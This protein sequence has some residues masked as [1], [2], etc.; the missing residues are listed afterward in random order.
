M[1]INRIFALILAALMLASMAIACSKENT[2]DKHAE[3]NKEEQTPDVSATPE[4]TEPAYTDKPVETSDPNVPSDYFYANLEENVP[5]TCDLDFDGIDDTVILVAD[6]Q[7][8]GT[9]YSMQFTLGINPNNTIS[10]DFDMESYYCKAFITD[11]DRFDSRLDV[12][13]CFGY[14]SDD[15]TTCLYRV[16][17]TGY[18]IDYFE[19]SAMVIPISCVDDETYAKD[20]QFNLGYRTEILGTTTVSILCEAGANGFKHA[21]DQYY[22]SESSIPVNVIAEVSVETIDDEGNANGEC[23]LKAGEKVVPLE[24]DCAT[25]VVIRLENGDRARIKIELHDGWCPYINGQP[26]ESYFEVIYAD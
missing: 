16:D 4:E 8:Y 19:E 2:D 20:G 10:L 5:F 12:I 15:Y 26:Q 1:K 21:V 14:D 22:Y 17:K 18:S 7:R 11:S 6:E 25:Y 3:N 9:Q 23:T 24:T 13:T